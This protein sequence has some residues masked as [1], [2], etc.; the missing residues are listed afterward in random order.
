MS[1]RDDYM[2]AVEARRVATV[3]VGMALVAPDTTLA[4]I[5]VLD[6]EQQVA[7]DYE[8]RLRRLVP[9]RVEP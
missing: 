1:L 8:E 3:A 5:L 6:A 7:S 9:R 4:Q 2:V